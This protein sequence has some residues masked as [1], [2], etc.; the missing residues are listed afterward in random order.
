VPDWPRAAS[1]GALAMNT[2]DM[3]LRRKSLEVW[4][5][6]ISR[7]ADPNEIAKG[8]TCDGWHEPGADT[9]RMPWRTPPQSSFRLPKHS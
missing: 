3:R 9:V 6:F 7:N 4:L 5:S 1:V 8:P 2:R